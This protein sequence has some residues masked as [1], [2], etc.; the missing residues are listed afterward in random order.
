MR[1]DR[2]I[3]C[4]ALYWPEPLTSVHRAHLLG[5]KAVEDQLDH[6][7]RPGERCPERPEWLHRVLT[8]FR[9]PQDLEPVPGPGT[10][11]RQLVFL[12]GAFLVT[13][14]SIQ[15]EL[16]KIMKKHEPDGGAKD[17]AWEI[18]GRG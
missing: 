11:L 2:Q 7:C 10:G 3:H 14:Q 17:L 4:T 5:S 1:T 16:A 13:T 9:H 8:H 15:K 6:T 18:E 12:K